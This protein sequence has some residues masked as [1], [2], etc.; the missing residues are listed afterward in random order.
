FAASATAPYWIGATLSLPLM[1]ALWFAPLLT[2]FHGVKPLPALKLSFMGCLR[3]ILP[4]S[5]Y[6]LAILAAL[7]V[8]V[9]LGLRIGLYDLGLWLIAPVLVPSIYT[10]YRDIYVASEADTPA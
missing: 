8:L 5:V 9:P 2:F 1:M 10:S 6:G 3:N 7:V 4:M